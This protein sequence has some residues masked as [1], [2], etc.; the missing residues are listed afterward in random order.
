M[1]EGQRMT[2]AHEAVEQLMRSGARR[3]LARE[4]GAL[5]VRELMEAEVAAQIGAGLGERAPDARSA[6][7]NG[8]RE[9]GVGHAGRARSSCAIPKLR[10]GSYFPSVSG[11][12]P[13]R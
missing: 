5:M 11:A 9:R 10:S 7:R 8:Y 4:R 2:A 13:A 6:Q 3:R 12:A 1:A